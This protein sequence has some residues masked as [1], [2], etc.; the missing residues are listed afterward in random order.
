MAFCELYGDIRAIYTASI[1]YEN[2]IKL[3]NKEFTTMHCATLQIVVLF[4][5]NLLQFKVPVSSSIMFSGIPSSN[6]SPAQA[7]DE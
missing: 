1:L 2:A 3:Q 4:W 5:G 6:P 7:P